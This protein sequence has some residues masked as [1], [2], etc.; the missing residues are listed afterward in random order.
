MNACEVQRKDN[1]VT[2]TLGPR[3]TAMEV[4]EVQQALREQLAAGAAQVVFDLSA[5]TSL[6]S[7]GIGL[8]VATSNSVRMV[9]GTLRV[10]EVN[11]S[12]RRLLEAMR[13]A[14][15]LNV[16]AAGAHRG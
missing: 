8:L 6:D 7:N 9:A 11:D 5:T 15:R 3:L 4:P 10:V 13:L 12:L 1:L 14:E 16:T 2:V